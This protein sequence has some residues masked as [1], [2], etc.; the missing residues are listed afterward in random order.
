M[1]VEHPDGQ[2]VGVLMTESQGGPATP[3]V[4]VS[5]SSKTVD[6][7]NKTIA[8]WSFFEVISSK[9]MKI[10]QMDNRQCTVRSGFKKG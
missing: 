10:A 2:N 7:T 5:Q 9:M 6:T 1:E 4:K 8:K 3:S